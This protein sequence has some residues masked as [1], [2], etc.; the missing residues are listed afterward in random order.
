[1]DLGEPFKREIRIS[2]G[3]DGTFIVHVCSDTRG[4]MSKSFGF[5]SIDDLLIW[6]AKHGAKS[7]VTKPND[8]GGFTTRLSEDDVVEDSADG[9]RGLTSAEAQRNIDRGGGLCG[10]DALNGLKR[11]SAAEAIREREDAVRQKF[12]ASQA[13]QAVR[14]ELQ[15]MADLPHPTPDKP[16]A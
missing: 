1:M 3:E 16:A 4:G 5:T 10:M 14:A 15:K 2:P 8:K 7:R 6:M 13:G 12:A 11:T 9:R